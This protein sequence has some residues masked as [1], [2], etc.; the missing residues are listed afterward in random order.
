MRHILQYL[1]CS[2]HILFTCVQILLCFCYFEGTQEIKCG[3]NEESGDIYISFESCQMAEKS[4]FVWKKS[5]QEITDF[6][7]GI[8]VKT[9]GSQ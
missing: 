9:S 6:S 5:Y 4:K 3:V 1:F 8:V 7:K 2:L